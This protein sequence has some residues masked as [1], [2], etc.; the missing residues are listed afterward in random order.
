MKTLIYITILFITTN[1]VGQTNS[2]RDASMCGIHFSS[3]VKRKFTSKDFMSCDYRIM[4]LDTN[5]KVVSFRISIAG[6]GI[7]YS[8][9]SIKGNQIPK[10]FQDYFMTGTKRNIMLEYIKSVNHQG[11]ELLLNPISIRL[12]Y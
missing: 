5:Y 12:N 8:E 11:Q 6:Q 7:S 9:N 1:V 4:A 10:E 3:E 2:E